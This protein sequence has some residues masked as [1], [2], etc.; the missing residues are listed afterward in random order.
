MRTASN[1]KK[2]HAIPCIAAI[3]FDLAGDFLSSYHSLSSAEL[4]S[5]QIAKPSQNAVP[6]ATLNP[7][8][9]LTDSLVAFCND[10]WIMRDWLILDDLHKDL[11]GS[12]DGAR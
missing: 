11:S 5:R 2:E 1:T 7:L 6:F 3:Y 10:K 12:R 4:R 9:T 8:L